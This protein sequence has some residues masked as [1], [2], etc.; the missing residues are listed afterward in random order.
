[1][2]R[3][4]ASAAIVILIVASCSTAASPEETAIEPS[5]T[6][7][8]A[9]AS[10]LAS[11]APPPVAS[12]APPPVATTSPSPARTPR[13]DGVVTSFK[14]VSPGTGWAETDHGLLVT[15]DDGSSWVDA[16][17]NGDLVL[18][19]QL[20]GDARLGTLA[21]DAID[22]QTAFVATEKTDGSTTTISIWHT[23][24]GGQTWRPAKLASVPALDTSSDCGCES[25]AV[26]I[27]AVDPLDVFADIVVF[28]GTDSESHDVFQSRDGGVTWA[29]L[30]I[31]IHANGSPGDLA[32]HFLTADTG[33]IV[34]DERTFTT[35]TGWGHWSEY[36]EQGSGAVP[37]PGFGPVTYLDD[38]HWIMSLTDAALIAESTD[39]GRTWTTHA[40]PFPKG[41]MSVSFVSAMT[42]IAT[43]GTT[44]GPPDNKVGPAETWISRDAGTTWTFVGKLPTSDT[45]RSVFVD[46]SHA[47]VITSAGGLATTSD[48]GATWSAI[49]GR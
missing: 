3:R 31:G 18:D 44:S 33:S 14:L 49:L 41:T 9:V 12:V 36:P 20:V 29:G 4:A 42:W 28:S 38:R 37:Y 13:L 7:S 22:G 32:I 39:A 24:D 48:G 15:H 30:S 8:S 1:M 5:P 43:I 16:S 11:V 21:M 34:F 2:P 46:P 10:P 25:L 23:T 17:P 26:L 19:Q 45:W 6:S 27:D 47:W 35:R 40:R